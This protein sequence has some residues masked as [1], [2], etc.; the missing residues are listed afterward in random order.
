MIKLNNITK[1]Y[2]GKTVIDNIAFEFECGKLYVIKG[3]SGCGK[4]TLLNIIGGIEKD[5]DGTVEY[6]FNSEREAISYIFQKSLL[7]SNIT[8]LDNLLLIENNID[9]IE[10][11]CNELK[12]AD[13]MNKY[14]E[15]LSG[16]ERQ[17]VAIARALL[18]QPNILLADEPTASLD[19]SNSYNIAEIIANLKND[20]RV[21]IVATHEKCFDEFA[22]E[23]I[24]LKYGV[25]EHTD[26]KQPR[27]TTENNYIYNQEYSENIKF[28]L[29]KFILARK[30]N[31]IK[32]GNILP[33]FIAFILIM[34]IGT[35]QN[36]FGSEY[37]RFV[38][39][40]YPMDMVV[41]QEH[42]FEKFEYKNQL[43]RFDKYI[44][45]ENSIN[46]YG[47]LDKKDSVINIDG[48]IIY[49]NFPENDYEIIASQGFIKYYFNS[50]KYEQFIGKKIT[51]YNKEFTVSGILN[52][53]DLLQIQEYINADVYYRHDVKEISIFIP[54]NTIKTF[55]EKTENEFVIFVCDDLPN[56]KNVLSA[57]RNLHEDEQPNQFYYDIADSMDTV[58]TISAVLS[59][60]LILCFLISCIFFSS[61]IQTELF[62]RKK[63]VGYLQIFG[64]TKQ[65]IGK[66]LFTEYLI[67]IV[68]SFCLSVVIYNLLVLLYRLIVGSFVYF[69]LIYVPV[70]FVLIISIYCISVKLSIGKTM[71]KSIVSLIT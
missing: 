30:P 36:S 20:N 50:E 33:M 59:I 12:I 4:T 25:I 18:K 29:L 58:N 63:E 23:I 43:K 16:G 34:L 14:P 7:L 54:Y 48:M 17:R 55:G 47:L 57:I 46:A 2:N 27:K 69:N 3:V 42:F 67:K 71:K 68:V 60:I 44:A 35:F 66:I 6:D 52:D 40:K 38:Q 62:Y 11:I 15:Q 28:S 64:L 61:V 45:T 53:L 31:L 65:K 19:E 39:D 9:Y 24:D 26:K 37:I 8:V 49:G 13:L 32:F 51:F 41:M 5:Y 22:D 70:L 56:N 21:I 1:K 10:K